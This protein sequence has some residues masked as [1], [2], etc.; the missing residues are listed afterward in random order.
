MV[1]RMELAARVA[2]A[3]EGAELSQAE[4][5][6]ELR[7][8]RSAVSKMETGEQRIEGIVLARMARL[9]GV[10]V[11][12]LLAEESERERSVPPAEAL[13]RSAGDVSSGDRRM[14]DEFLGVCRDYAALKGLVGGGS[15]G[16]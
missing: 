5:A 2:R 3:R 16:R 15:R 10:S 1:E 4:V 9:Y 11:S 12:E 8:P 13:L 14:L 7:L 6:G